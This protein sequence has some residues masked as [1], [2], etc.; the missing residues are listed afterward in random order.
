MLRYS[1]CFVN[2]LFEDV[3]FRYVAEINLTENKLFVLYPSVC[4]F[5]TV[6]LCDFVYSH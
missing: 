6:M 2:Q 1:S 4:L 3:A 5:F